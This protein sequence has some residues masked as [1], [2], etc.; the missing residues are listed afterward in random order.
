MC[1]KEETKFINTKLKGFDISNYTFFKVR[2]LGEA[3]EEDREFET[4]R[5]G[6][7]DK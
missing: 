7:W 3:T 5:Q 2:K 4:R 6:N 1:K